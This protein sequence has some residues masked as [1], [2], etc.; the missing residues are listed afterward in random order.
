MTTFELNDKTEL[1]A[2]VTAA[3]R[4]ERAAFGTL[5]E[6]F[7]R[8]VRI[9]IGREATAERAQRIGDLARFFHDLPGVFVGGADAEARGVCQLLD[10]RG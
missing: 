9:R 8:H 6:R 10:P 2:L 1:I 4:G 7:E 5:F 3:Q